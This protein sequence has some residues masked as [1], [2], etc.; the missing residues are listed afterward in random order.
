MDCYTVSKIYADW[1]EAEETADETALTEE[2]VLNTFDKFM[3]SMDDARVPASG[4]IL[5]VTPAV[6]TIIKNAKEIVR[7][8]NLQTNNT[9][10]RRQ[11]SRI[12]EVQIEKVPSELMK[13]KYDFTAGWKATEDADQINMMLIHPLAIITPISYQF[14]QLDPPSAGSEGKW[15]YF[16]ESFEDVFILNKKKKAICFNISK[17][18][19]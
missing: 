19:A 3:Q 9:T 12:D 15:V 7:T 2:N 16:E 13:T 14:A 18:A 1:T 5:Y 11:I 17:H 6:N 10:V 8:L 4:R